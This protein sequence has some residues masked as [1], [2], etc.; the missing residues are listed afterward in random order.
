MKGPRDVV[1]SNELPGTS[2]W[3]NIAVAARARSDVVR[4]F[5][6]PYAGGGA[7]IFRPWITALA[8]AI[9]VCPVQLPGRED[10][11]R[12]P[13]LSDLSVLVPR[14]GEALRGRLEPPFVLF[15]H[16]MGAFIAFQLARHLRRERCAGP[17]MLI[18]SGARAPQ[19]PDPDPQSHLLPADL[20]LKDLQR[21]GGIPPELLNHPELI[22]LLLPTLSAD[23][24]LCET[25]VYRDEPPLDCPIVVYGGQSDDK[26]PAAHLSPWKVQTARG[27]QLRMFPGNHFFF[28]K[29]ARTA[30]L[31]VLRDELDSYMRPEIA[32]P[33]ISP[34]AGIE[35][36]IAEVW[37]EVLRKPTVGPDDNFFDLGGNSLLM[38][39]MHFRLRQSLST[40]LSVLDMFR[41]PT[42]RL[43]A[44]A[45][46]PS[47][48]PASAG[49]LA[50]FEKE[51][52]RE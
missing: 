16:S 14:L 36:T 38:V 11:W 1:S 20:L 21:Y 35:R 41:Y 4:L 50:R 39:Q 5:C 22:S 28:L 42:I 12:E 23:L 25:Y 18:V 17:A 7:S 33:A 46:E 8:P 9:D 40:S 6:F 51:S 10:R 48:L 15:G 24:A 47:A 52:H 32:T 2:R 27:F 13:P 30:V 34:R 37:R 3:T 45:I 44:N 29:E 26:V 19:I 49:P 43:L 31:Q